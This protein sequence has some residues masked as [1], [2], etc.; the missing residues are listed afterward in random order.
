ML[1]LKRTNILHRL[2]N[3]NPLYFTLIYILL[4]W[5]VLLSTIFLNIDLIIIKFP[6]IF[7]ILSMIVTLIPILMTFYHIMYFRKSVDSF[8]RLFSLYIQ[9]VLLFGTIYFIMQSGLVQRS[10]LGG[11]IHY[12]FVSETP[13]S[14]INNDWVTQIVDHDSNKTETLYNA[15]IS[16]LDCLH[17]SLVTSST[18]GY[19]DMT[20]K[21]LQA[22]LI[23]DFQIVISFLIVAF[24]IGIFLSGKDRKGELE[25]IKTLDLDE[26]DIIEAN[27]N[28]LDI[29]KTQLES[30]I[31]KLK[32]TL[33]KVSH[34]SIR[35][36]KK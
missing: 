3:R 34:E 14:N 8:I 15:F 23:V 9:I 18:V 28:Q 22:K 7:H 10:F 20:P 21:T 13:I 33:E 17:F 25:I 31:N 4:I 2:L 27:D 5:I 24:G 30:K 6:R 32:N 16:Y 19:G 11:N 35:R 12:S 26:K 1:R 36:Y 29:Y